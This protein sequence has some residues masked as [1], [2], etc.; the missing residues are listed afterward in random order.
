[1]ITYKVETEVTFEPKLWILKWPKAEEARMKLAL[2]LIQ[3]GLRVSGSKAL[4]LL[5][6]YFP[7]ELKWAEYLGHSRNA[8]NLGIGTLLPPVGSHDTD[9]FAAQD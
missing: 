8:S 3:L 2:W 9:P 7:H 4:I 6:Q 1:M 5:P